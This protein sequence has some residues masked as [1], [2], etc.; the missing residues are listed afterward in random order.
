L[1]VKKSGR[2]VAD[3]PNSAL[4]DEAPVYH[5]P[6]MQPETATPIEVD[7]IEASSAE[8]GLDVYAHHRPSDDRVEGMGLSP[9]R[10]HGGDEHGC[11]C[12]AS[13]SA[14]IRVKESGGGSQ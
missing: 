4:T 6:I 14:V 3:I 5:R 7:Q 13:D 2:I 12:R 8:F 9:I 10:P 11:A 1:R